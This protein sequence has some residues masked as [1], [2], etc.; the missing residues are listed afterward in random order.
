MTT[1]PLLFHYRKQIYQVQFRPGFLV[2]CLFFFSL[3]CALGVWQLHRYDYKKTLLQTYQ[4][5]LADTPRPLSANPPPFQRIITS[6]EYVNAFTVLVQN[7]FYRDQ[8]GYDV[9]TPLR[10][11]GDKNLLLVER[12]WIP[13]AGRDTIKSVT[14]TKHIIQ[15][16]IKYLDEY[17]FILGKNI[18]APKVSPIVIQKID[19]KELSQLSHQTFYPFILRLNASEPHGFV[20]DWTISTVMPER[21]MGYAVQWFAMAIVLL[22]AYFCFC[23]ERI[24][25]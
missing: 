15:G 25:K 7:R 11:P 8:I 22:I 12:G 13:E 14:G 23:C 4:Q 9:L 24:K 16:Y 10:I 6:G 19:T 5:R 2:F 1:K 21:H 17:Q 3:F 20:R 18:L